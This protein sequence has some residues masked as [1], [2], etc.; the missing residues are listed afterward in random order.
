MKLLPALENEIAELAAR[1][2]TPRREVIE[3]PDGTFE[4]IS[5]RDRFGEVCMVIQRPN[6]KVITFR[7]GFYPQGILR[8]L[9]GGINHGEPIEAALLREVDEETGLEV[10]IERF[11]AVIVYR[12]P[13]D[14][15]DHAAFVTFAFLLAERGGLLACYDPAE[16]IETFGEATP[17]EL[18]E[19]A[20]TLHNLDSAFSN[21]IRG[22]WRSWGLQ[23]AIVHQVVGEL[24]S[25]R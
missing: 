9:T 7:K 4:P 24:L 6:G 16:Q 13:Q 21:H 10:T 19:I 11:L 3:L 2:G 15:P 8:L 5:L 12:M 22:N 17:A 20:G 14:P 23:R 1:Y 18:L 25:S